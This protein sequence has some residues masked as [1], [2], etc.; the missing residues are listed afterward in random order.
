[1]S[2]CAYGVAELV[3]HHEIENEE[4]FNEHFEKHQLKWEDCS[5][6]RIFA[7]EVQIREVFENPVPY[8]HPLGAR[9][10]LTLVFPQDGLRTSRRFSELI[11]STTIE[12]IRQIGESVGVKDFGKGAHPFFRV[13]FQGN[14]APTWKSYYVKGNFLSEKRAML[15]S[16]RLAWRMWQINDLYSSKKAADLRV[17][18]KMLGLQPHGTTAQ[19]LER[20]V[21]FI[22]QKMNAKIV[23]DAS[24]AVKEALGDEGVP[25]VKEDDINE[26]AEAN[27]NSK[28][29]T[30]QDTDLKKTNQD[31]KS[32]Q[33]FRI[34][35]NGMVVLA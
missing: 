23:K 33:Q 15:R 34:S 22:I 12:E 4:V 30:M 3:G 16:V 21:T 29:N 26:A 11:T 35:A 17:E 28:Q 13:K 31:Q 27:E 8:H 18:A 7:W 25:E 6:K 14:G 5:Y 1:M 19:V 24:A 9:R 20:V 10:W 32:T 2:G